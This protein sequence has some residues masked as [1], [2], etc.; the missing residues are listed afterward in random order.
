MTA[1]LLSRTNTSSKACF[2]LSALAVMIFSPCAFAATESICPGGSAPRSDIVYC[3][4]FENLASCRNGREDE[5]LRQNKL[6][7]HRSDLP[8]Y[9]VKSG[10]AAAGNGFLVGK[11]ASGGTGPGYMNETIPGGPYQAVSLRFYI[12]FGPGWMS[13]THNHGPGINGSGSGCHLHGQFEQSQFSYYTYNTGNCGP[14]S[15]DL[16]PNQPHLPLIRNNRWYLVEEQRIADSRCRNAGDAHGCNGIYRLWIDEQL[17]AEYTDINYGGVVNGLRFGDF[18]GPRDYYHVRVPAWEPEIYFDNFAISRTGTYIGPARNENSR[19]QADPLSPYANYQGIEPFIGRH[20]VSDCSTPS[21]YLGTNYGQEWR[22]GALLQ[23]TIAHRGFTDR[24]GGS[25]DKALRVDISSSSGGGGVYWERWRGRQD[26]II[27]PQQVI[28]GWIYLPSSND[29]SNDPA[30]V[31]F[32]GYACAGGSCE[33]AQ[34][35]NYVALTV[36]EGRYALVQRTRASMPS[37]VLVAA[38]DRSVKFDQWQEFEII[39]WQDKKVSLTI[40]RQRL[41]SKYSL[42]LN[43]DWLFSGTVDNGAVLGVID[44]SGEPRFTV[45]YDDVSLGS[46]SFWSCDGWHSSGCPFGSGEPDSE[47]PARPTG[48][49]V[50]VE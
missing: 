10:A 47:S 13:Y 5:C 35:G 20:P 30:L 22:N 7:A 34:W 23:S 18:W 43:V 36:H 21:G 25:A 27:F 11:G 28:H 29:Y 50:R 41:Y 38:S 26:M 49:N 15:F 45:Y 40:E 12:K 3:L 32:R 46:A 24:C 31:G 44:F 33:G 17:V 48:L 4:D 6:F 8:G 42:P 39:V 16:A 14:G 37:P 1:Q 2:V 19:G 9:L